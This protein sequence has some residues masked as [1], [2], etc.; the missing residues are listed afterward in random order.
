MQRTKRRYIADI[1]VN[2]LGL[3]CSPTSPF[4]ISDN[5]AGVSTLYNC[6]GTK[7]PLTVTVPPPSGSTGTSAPTGV[8]FNGNAG[9]FQ[10][11]SGAK[12]GTSLFIFSA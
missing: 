3:A 10:V 5:G 11:N 8:V 1:L 12:T 2:P 9:S 6:A 4:W 7:F